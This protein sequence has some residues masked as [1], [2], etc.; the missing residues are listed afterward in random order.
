MRR[1]RINWNKTKAQVIIN[2]QHHLLPEQT[3]LLNK[4]F[5]YNHWEL[6]LVPAEGW[7]KKEMLKIANS[8]IDINEIVFV[9][10]VPLLLAITCNKGNIPYLFFNPNREKKELP[11]GKV[12]F[13]VPKEGWKLLYV[14]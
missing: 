12:I 13:T 6:R 7:N 9:S 8:I 2:E 5:G 4:E 14:N 1:R 11:N 3:M 10:P